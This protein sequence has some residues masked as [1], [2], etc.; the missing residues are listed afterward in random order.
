MPAKIGNGDD[1]ANNLYWGAAYGVRTFFQKAQEWRLI[2]EVK[3]PN[4]A[5]LERVVFKHNSKDV[6]LVADA[7]RG[8]EIRQTTID[9]LR[10]AAGTQV[11][12]INVRLNSKRLSLNAGGGADLV[13]YV[14]HDGLMD[15]TFTEYP[16]KS[17]ERQRDV[18]ILACSSKP[19][20]G[21]AIRQT[22]ANPLLWTTGLMAPEAYVL[23][24]AIDGWIANER[25][26]AVR[27]R[28]ATAYNSYQK[29]GMKAALNLFSNG[30]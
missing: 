18:M 12:T 30:W 20:F 7:Y 11:E 14:G 16:R 23:R 26:E 24:S 19:Y 28:A 29:C 3:N 13:A 8:R 21:E 27:R 4:H 9:F 2:D 6:Y 22:G 17:D 1:P 10:Y 5:V 15:F 25:G